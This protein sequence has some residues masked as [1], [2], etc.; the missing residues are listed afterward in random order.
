MDAFWKQALACL[1]K[2]QGPGLFPGLIF[3]L[4]R[5][6]QAQGVHI[7]ALEPAIALSVSLAWMLTAWTLTV[8]MSSP[9]VKVLAVV[10]FPA[11][12][13][14][15]VAPAPLFPV[16]FRPVVTG[17]GLHPVR[18]CP[19][20]PVA[21]PEP[22]SW[23]QDVSWAQLLDHL[24]AVRGRG[25]ADVYADV[26]LRQGWRGHC[27]KAQQGR[28]HGLEG[29]VIHV[30]SPCQPLRIGRGVGCGRSGSGPLGDLGRVLSIWHEHTPCQV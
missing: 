8:F 11:P 21:I 26:E 13:L 22:E 6:A 7:Q 2:Q 3:C 16:R 28:E 27:S 10:R 29:S 18:F 25:R 17:P 14:E 12:W 9:L 15:V 24:V 1:G 20:V 5:R 23:N 4:L 19:A 30:P